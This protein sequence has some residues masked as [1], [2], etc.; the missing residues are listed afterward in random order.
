MAS[1]SGVIPQGFN[2]LLHKTNT[3]SRIDKRS[4]PAQA[5]AAGVDICYEDDV[6][7]TRRVGDRGK[8]V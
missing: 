3:R 6:V 5:Q 1:T 8:S 2:G 7:L 4:I